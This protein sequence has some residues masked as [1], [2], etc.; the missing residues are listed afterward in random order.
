MRLRVAGAVAA[1]LSR[2]W[3]LTLLVPVV[4]GVPLRTPLVTPLVLRLSQA[5]RL[6]G[7]HVYGL[8]PPLALSV[9][10]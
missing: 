3:T 9:V 8:V 10:L 2:T 5:G 7:L 1:A 6:T 4:G